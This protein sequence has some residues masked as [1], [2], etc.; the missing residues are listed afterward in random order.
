MLATLAGEVPKGPGWLY[1]VK[2]DGYRTIA[3]LRGGEASLTSR[4]G[5]DQTARFASIARALPGALRSPDCVVDGEICALDSHGRPSFAEMQQGSGKTV[6]YLFDLL[7]L[8][9]RPLLDLPLVER[10]EMLLALVDRDGG[11]VRVSDTFDDGEALYRAAR[12][13]G[14]E[15]I[16][17]KRGQSRY[18]P[19]KRTGDWIKVKV[20]ERQEFVIAGYT[21]GT[22]RR[23]VS[24]GALV[25]GVFEGDDLVWVGNCGTGFTDAEIDRLLGKLRPLERA[26]SPFKVVP[27]MPRVRKD[28]VVWVTPKLV[29]EVEF[30][31]WT[32]ERRLRAPSYQGLREDK[33]SVSVT[34]ERPVRAGGRKRLEDATASKSR[35]GVLARRGHHKG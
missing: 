29:C 15:G 13:Q 23:A 33:P 35:Q 24:L 11:T 19:G 10:H 26:T 4:T 9:A 6:V 25:L 31:E 27:K 17:A 28:D 5:K 14:L 2:W 34:H 7:E 12:D 1:E 30:V 18:Q 22:G 21:R 20:H 3:R 16:V 8:D 32:A